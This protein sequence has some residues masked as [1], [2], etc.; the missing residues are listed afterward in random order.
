M[1]FQKFCVFAVKNFF[2]HIG[3][4]NRLRVDCEPENN[5]NFLLEGLSMRM[6]Q[7]CGIYSLHNRK[8]VSI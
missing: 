8:V 6:G 2:L 3:I 1:N 4:I 5:Y 7:F